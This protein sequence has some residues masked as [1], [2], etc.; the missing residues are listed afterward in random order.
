MTRGL[1]L[2][3][4]ISISVF[5]TLIG[6]KTDKL[7]DVVVNVP[8]HAPTLDSIRSISPNRIKLDWSFVTE[9]IDG[10]Y[11]ERALGSDTTFQRSS[12]IPSNRRSITDSLLQAGTSYRYRMLAYHGDL[13]SLPSTELSSITFPAIPNTPENLVATAIAGP[14]VRLNWSSTASQ[15]DSFRIV[16]KV[17]NGS[18]L[19][20]ANVIGTARSYLDST[21]AAG[22]IYT[23]SISAFN[24]S[25]SSGYST[26]ARTNTANPI[27]DAPSMLRSDSIAPHYV[28][29]QWQDNTAIEDGF[30]I[31]RRVTGTDTFAAVGQSGR[32]QTVFHDITI[33]PVTSYDFA[34]I[35]YNANGRSELSNSIT[36]HS[37]NVTPDPPS[38]LVALAY[39]PFSVH[40]AWHDNSTNE[41]SFRIERRA[42]WSAFMPVGYPPANST[43]WLDSNCVPSTRYFYRVCAINAIG[44]S[45]YSNID[46]TT[47]SAEIPAAPTN[48]VARSVASNRITLSWQIHSTNETGFMI[49]R[50]VGYDGAFA[51]LRY[52]GPHLDDADDSSPQPNTTYGYRVCAVNNELQSAPSNVSFAMTTSS[53]L[54]VGSLSTVGSPVSIVRDRT[55]VYLASEINGLKVVNVAYSTTPQL[56]ASLALPAW[57]KD[58]FY[59]DDTLYCA[60]SGSGIQI[61]AVGNPAEPRIVGSYSSTG[62]AISIIM[63]GTLGYILDY[64]HGLQIVNFHNYANPTFVG[65]YTED[66]QFAAPQQFAVEGSFVYLAYGAGGFRIIDCSSPDRPRR[67][68]SVIPANS[69]GFCSSVAVHNHV[70]YVGYGTDGFRA[71]DVSV[72]AQ[73]VELI[74]IPL[75]DYILKN[76]VFDNYLYLA[77]N[78]N[79]VAVYNIARPSQPVFCCRIGTTETASDVEADGNLLY[80][81]DLNRGFRVVQM[82]LP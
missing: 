42:S 14:K 31:M 82:S 15:N 37:S 75:N 49:Q 5:L 53:A 81:T 27:P 4:F 57:T 21:V 32:D 26:E 24:Q 65:E 58:V 61:V 1:L 60:N 10:F 28:G 55:Y 45:E 80:M 17:L 77:C 74:N 68:F 9:Q 47:T 11:Y 3:L 33:A 35:A 63:V 8:P 59:R 66:L 62:S 72:P 30:L 40:L 70:A 54:E 23:Y 52:V 56:V 48:L 67:V 41:D 19:P 36:I 50:C 78:F 22:R 64:V 43:E 46:S 29:L 25:G 73:P 12:W 18:Y 7:A 2:G 20:L 39:T 44:F 13:V 79:G 76:R 34:V 16:R 69:S 51:T 71:Y 6:C 38:Y